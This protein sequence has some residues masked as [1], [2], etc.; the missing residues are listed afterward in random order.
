MKEIVTC[1]EM[2]ALDRN[3]IEKMK[4]PSC[5][6]ME[7]AALKTAEEMEKFFAER[8]EKERILCVC[9]SGNN[10]GDGAALARILFLHGFQAEIYMAGS[11]EHMT[12]E[13]KRQLEIAGNYHVPIVNNPEWGEYTT[14]VDAIFGVGLTRPVE[15]RYA[16]LIRR[17]NQTGAWKVAVDIPS[18]VNGDT[19][20]EM[21]TAFHADLTV[22]FGFVKA[23]LCLYPGR[24]LAG[25]TA[26]ADIGIYR[27][28]GERGKYFI[29]EK[30]DLAGLPARPP[31]GNKG[32]FGKVLAVAGSPGMCGA[33]CFCGAAAFASGAGMVRIFTPEENRIPLQTLLPEAILTC[34]KGEE[35]METAFR[36]CDVLIIG[37]GLGTSG[38]SAES[39]FWFLKK[40]FQEKKPVIL[41]ADG[42][43][44]LSE[45][46]GWKPFLGGNVIVTPHMGEMSR[47]TGKSIEEIKKNRI[48][49]AVSYA[50]ET[51][52]VCVLKDACTVTAGPDGEAFIN[53]S[54]NSGMGVAGSGDV[55]C[56]VLAGMACM[57]RHSPE[58]T[59]SL[60]KP[61]AL[62]VF[63]HGK[64][65][66]R[67]AEKK[68]QYGM[69]AGDLIPEISYALQDG[70]SHEA[71]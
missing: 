25:R 64:A 70:G 61:A 30:E 36:W 32:T 46:P 71:L 68:G 50:E 51:G 39:A 1:Q 20:M 11:Q 13:T 45:N 59:A 49:A 2:K 38:G 6:L 26:A 53:L 62:G 10:G 19:G 40:A 37:P 18:G 65:G 42:L 56:G 9:G 5:V 66:D 55:L 47:L 29:M 31:Y 7:R 8:K 23:G 15:G 14:I 41:D 33:A 63:L 60:L 24:L 4:V 54:G 57:F 3:T 21:G 52:T 12:E 43:N 48:E 58:G 17:M 28:P 35:A 34:E 27:K 69:T 67:A 16:E 44:L 22:T